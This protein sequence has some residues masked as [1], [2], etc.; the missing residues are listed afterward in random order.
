MQMVIV[1]NGVQMSGEVD[2]LE[3]LLGKDVV[4]SELAK[5]RLHWSETKRQYI[6]ISDMDTQYLMNVISKAYLHAQ[7]EHMV[8]LVKARTAKSYKNF[9]TVLT[10]GVK[11]NTEL[12]ILLEELAKR[13]SDI[14]SFI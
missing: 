14:R 1:H 9:V 12:Q 8:E 10:E 7:N 11:I 13:A 3:K 5:N 2:A 4:A 6:K